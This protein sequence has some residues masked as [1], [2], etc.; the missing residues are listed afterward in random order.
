MLV[1]SNHFSLSNSEGTSPP[2]CADQ[3]PHSDKVARGGI[4]TPEAPKVWL[5]DTD[6]IQCLAPYLMAYTKH[7]LA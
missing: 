7:R 1:S 3:I 2:A 6:P 4:Q 5:N